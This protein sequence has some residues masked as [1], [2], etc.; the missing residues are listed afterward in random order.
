MQET[1]LDATIEEP[2]DAPPRP[3]GWRDAVDNPWL[4]LAMLFFVTAALGL[5]VLW[6]SRGFSTVWKIVLTVVVIAWTVLILWLFWLVM[7]LC[8]TRIVDAL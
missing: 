2:T 5:P 7:V 4:V 3:Q 1:P 8:Y 6:I